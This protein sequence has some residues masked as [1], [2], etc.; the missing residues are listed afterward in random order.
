MIQVHWLRAQL[1]CALVALLVPSNLIECQMTTTTTTTTKH[2]ECL[3]VCIDFHWLLCRHQSIASL[4]AIKRAPSSLFFCVFQQA[5]ND[6]DNDKIAFE[7][8]Y[9]VMKARERERER[10]RSLIEEALVW[11]GFISFIV[12]FIYICVLSLYSTVCLFVCVCVCLSVCR[13]FRVHCE[14]F[15]RRWLNSQSASFPQSDQANARKDYCC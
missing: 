11:F 14:S 4:S 12:P 9:K 7:R 5:N 15:C 3:C 6:N 13:S 10:E 8:T 1:N 2:I